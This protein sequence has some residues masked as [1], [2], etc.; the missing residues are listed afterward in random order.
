MESQFQQPQ[1][2]NTNASELK[3][4]EPLPQSLE[5]GQWIVRQISSSLAQ[6]PNYFGSYFN[7]YKQLVITILLLIAATI[8]LRIFVA[9]IDA[10]DDLPLVA[11]TFELVGIGYC[12]W[13]V[14]RYLLK[15]SRRQELSQEIQKFLEQEQQDLKQTIDEV[16]IE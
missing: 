3:A 7:E 14:N 13:F 10:I 9:I 16:S 4:L 8:A 2:D 1:D 15:S 5:K 6:I 12:I 11:P